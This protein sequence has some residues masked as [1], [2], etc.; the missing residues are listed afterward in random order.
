MMLHKASHLSQQHSIRL[1]SE[2]SFSGMGGSLWLEIDSEI[3][4]FLCSTLLIHCLFSCF[5]LPLWQLQCLFP[6]LLSCAKFLSLPT[7]L[8]FP[9]PLEQAR[10]RF[11][12]GLLPLSSSD[13]VPDSPLGPSSGHSSSLTEKTSASVGILTEG[14]V[15]TK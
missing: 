10:P 14:S 12:W 2:L 7:R 1:C 3:K 9:R 11:G 5:S 6:D 15:K 8:I 4:V 13:S